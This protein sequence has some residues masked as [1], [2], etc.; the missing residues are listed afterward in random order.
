MRYSSGGICR[1]GALGAG[2]AA[3]HSKPA[4]R[5]N[6]Y[7]KY[8]VDGGLLGSI[9]C[10]YATWKY[11][12][13]QLHD[14]SLSNLFGLGAIFILP[15]AISAEFTAMVSGAVGG[16]L[17]GSLLCTIIHGNA[18][19]RMAATAKEGEVLVVDMKNVHSLYPHV[20]EGQKH[21]ADELSNGLEEQ[22]DA[23]F[24]HPTDNNFYK[25]VSE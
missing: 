20:Q 19:Q 1:M 2:L 14:H 5:L 17:A 16:A 18:F 25:G 3:I 22:D 21:A 10:A 24:E 13:A 23:T 8:M 15:E 6:R 7:V 4:S 11:Y 12:D 9:S